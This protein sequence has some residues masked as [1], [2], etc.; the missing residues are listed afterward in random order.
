MHSLDPL[1]TAMQQMINIS[2]EELY[3]FLAKCHVKNYKR[4]EVLTAPG[5]Y[6][7]EVFFVLSGLLRVG[8]TDQQGTDHTVYFA[9]ENGFVCDYSAFMRK[10][11][12]LYQVEA[13]EDTEVAV[14]TRE[15]IE[16]GYAALKEGEKM[17]RLIAENY[18][19]YHDERIKNQ[20]IRSAKERYDM[21]SQFFPNIHNRVPQ[22][23]IAS[24][25]GITPV[26][27]SRLKKQEFTKV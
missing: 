12:S 16:W 7:E 24:Y 26:H 21:I 4:K 19:I 1:K 11:Q 23:L 6:P 2:D 13:L 5:S 25:L 3:A 17:G 8:V 10:D 27:L 15:A 9:Y 18:F 20:Y 14:L 22:H